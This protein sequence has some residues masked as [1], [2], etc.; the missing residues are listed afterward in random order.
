LLQVGAWQH[1]EK[2]IGELPT[3]YAVAQPIIAKALGKLIH[4][5]MQPIHKR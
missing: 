3:H 5:T 1:A 2:I 4:T